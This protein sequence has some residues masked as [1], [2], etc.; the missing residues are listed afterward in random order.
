LRRTVE[1][2]GFPLHAARFSASAISR[3]PLFDLLDEDLA[4]EHQSIIACG[5]R[6]SGEMSRHFRICRL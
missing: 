3:E 4:R 5:G 1:S 2:P 6:S